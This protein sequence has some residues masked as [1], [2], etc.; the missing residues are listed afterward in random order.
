MTKRGKTSNTG[1]IAIEINSSYA[2]TVVRFSNSY[3]LSILVRVVNSLTE[4][5]S[6]LGNNFDLYNP[7]TS[8]CST[9]VKDMIGL[10]FLTFKR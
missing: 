4:K 8:V 3:A 9:D 6:R 2:D 10:K 7:M 1:I 5:Y